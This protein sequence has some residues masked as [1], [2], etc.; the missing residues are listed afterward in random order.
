[1]KLRGNMELEPSSD[2]KK[3]LKGSATAAAAQRIRQLRKEGKDVIDFTQGRPE[4]PD[5]Y[6]PTGFVRGM[7]NAVNPRHL[8]KQRIIY[9]SVA[10]IDDLREVLAKEFSKELGVDYSG[11]EIIVGPGGRALLETALR[12]VVDLGDGQDEVL[13]ATP[14]WPS[15]SQLIKSAGGKPI[16]IR[17][18]PPHFK[19]KCGDIERRLLD[20]R[21]AAVL[22]NSPNNPTGAIIDGEELEKIAK[23]MKDRERKKE[24]PHRKPVALILD[25]LYKDITFNRNAKAIVSI[26]EHFKDRTIIVDGASKTFNATGLRLAY[27][28]GPKSL[29]RA[30]I[31]IQSLRTGNANS[32]AQYGLLAALTKYS[33][34]TERE[35][36][37]FWRRHK[38]RRDYAYKELS[39]VDGLELL[40]P[41]GTFYIWVRVP[42]G[43]NKAYQTDNQLV[44]AL[45]EKK[46]VGVIAGEEFDCPGYI[47]I[48]LATS[49]RNVREGLFRIQEFFEEIS[50]EKF[51]ENKNI[52]L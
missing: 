47:R 7:V 52:Q 40:R 35:V 28:A 27:A 14:C 44:Q 49:M 22:L 21:L 9:T 37:M 10:G 38:K 32:V 36:E 34:D 48:S 26:D 12:A 45:L 41:E 1:L 46:Q 19:L 13:Y 23:V 24:I 50:N 17:L 15:Y 20:A 29:I 25:W 51:E 43:L 2:L 3:W 4:P 8:S 16:A 31:D 18:K 11:A 30:M 42:I 33:K 6:L 39:K 5:F